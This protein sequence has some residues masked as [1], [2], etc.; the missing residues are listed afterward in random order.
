MKPA[1]LI[2]G[3]CLIIVTVICLRSTGN[4]HRGLVTAP[5]VYQ[6]GW[7][8]T[9]V[10]DPARSGIRAQWTAFGVGG[11]SGE[12]HGDPPWVLFVESSR[13]VWWYDGE[14]AHLAQPYKWGGGHMAA[15][16][17]DDADIPWEF[18][19]A[20]QEFDRRMS[21]SGSGDRSSTTRAA[22]E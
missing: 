3:A 13:R 21:Q 10:V 7:R 17:T 2:L 8:R 6:I 5:G 20:V 12:I 19:L 11:N 9:L 22:T 15:I 4:Y 14:N 18:R 1:L 16:P